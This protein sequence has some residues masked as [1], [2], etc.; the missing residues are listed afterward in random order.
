MEEK[1]LISIPQR[2]YLPKICYGCGLN[3][4][5]RLALCQPCLAMLKPLANPCWI[6]AEPQSDNCSVYCLDCIKIDSNIHRFYAFYQYAHPLNRLIHYFKFK[7]HY[8]LKNTLTHVFLDKLPPE[9]L[10]SECLIPVPLH[11][12][13]LGNRGYHQTL[14]L[15]QAFSAKTAIPYSLKF[16]QKNKHTPSQMKLDRATRQENLYQAFNFSPPPF[17]HITIVDDISTTGATINAMA[18]G[19]QQMGVEKIDVWCLAKV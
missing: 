6:C 12:R 3:F 17:K 1:I 8:G 16:C 18:M 14:M 4:K 13:K 19:F 7:H 2:L 11:P 9:A 10:K 5:T 15:C